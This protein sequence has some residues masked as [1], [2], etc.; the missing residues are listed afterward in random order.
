[1]A[2]LS[3]RLRKVP[4]EPTENSQAESQEEKEKVS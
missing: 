1:V 4:E 3:G 2:R